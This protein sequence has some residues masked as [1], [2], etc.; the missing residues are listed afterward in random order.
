MR[1]IKQ[2]S[3]TTFIFFSSSTLSS[4]VF[5]F[6]YLISV[7]IPRPRVVVDVD[8][9]SWREITHGGKRKKQPGFKLNAPDFINKTS[10][11][12]EGAR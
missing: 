7:L 6:F 8:V 12:S 4:V 5:F 10:L 3:K 9:D 2:I 1:K 11:R